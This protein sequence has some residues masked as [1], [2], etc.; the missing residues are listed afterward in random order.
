MGK[1]EIDSSLPEFLQE[2]IEAF[3]IGK[4]KY[5]KGGYYQFDMDY[6]DLQTEINI[7]E[8]EQLIT[9]DEAWALREKYLGL[10]RC[11]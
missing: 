7:C 9:S 2:A 4:E 5:E 11:N 3:L 10:E 8:V 6:C 1:Y